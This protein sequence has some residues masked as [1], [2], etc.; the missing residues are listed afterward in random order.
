MWLF[1]FV[2]TSISMITFPLDTPSNSFLLSASLDESKFGKRGYVPRKNVK[3]ENCQS[4]IGDQVSTSSLW[5]PS[6][7]G[8][9]TTPYETARNMFK[10]SLIEQ[11]LFGSK[12][13]IVI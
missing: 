13:E 11:I 9:F 6:S 7:L 3:F 5:Y 4:P 1:W 12:I 8:K 10:K 2:F